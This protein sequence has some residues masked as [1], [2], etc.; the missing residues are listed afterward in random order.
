MVR[1]VGEV[2]STVVSWALPGKIRPHAILVIVIE[3]C[4][5]GERGVGSVKRIPSKGLSVKCDELTSRVS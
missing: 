1:Q 3:A 2:S 5:P 4:K